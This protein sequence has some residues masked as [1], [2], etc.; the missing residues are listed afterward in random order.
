MR[1]GSDGIEPSGP[2]ASVSLCPVR[3]AVVVE[4]RYVPL[5]FYT[6]IRG[7]PS[8]AHVSPA[9]SAALFTHCAPVTTQ[10]FVVM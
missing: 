5:A 4:G 10:I 1:R 9:P 6:V 7:S 3:T 2:A 8:E